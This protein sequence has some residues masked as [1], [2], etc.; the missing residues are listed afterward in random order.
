MSLIVKDISGGYPHHKVLSNISFALEAGEVLC[1]MGP[2]GSG[3][4]TLFKMLLRFLPLESGSI[5]IN[6]ESS[7]LFSQKDYAKQIAYIPQEHTP[8]FAYTVFE[9]VLMGRTCHLSKLG[10][11]R[12]KDHAAVMD[13]LRLLNIEHL[14]Q[15][16]YTELS[17]GQRQ[18]VLIARAICQ[19][20]KILIMDEPTANLDYANRELI[21]SAVRTLS[22]RG[23]SIILSTHSP[24]QPFSLAHKV[25]LLKKGTTIGYGSPL[26]VLTPDVLES[27]FDIP[28]DIVHVMD[29]DKKSH[30]LCLP[31]RKGS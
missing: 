2:N 11:P 21:A 28:M 30:Y 18:L 3:K 15:H 19:D 1:V 8:T 7:H 29:R 10:S 27:L 12:T 13:A 24:D 23:Y 9:M 26:E 20:S 22:S 4:S 16:H 5:S 14:A 17:G 6:G 31:V 25:L